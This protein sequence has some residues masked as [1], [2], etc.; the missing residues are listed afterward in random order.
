MGP[1]D[2]TLIILFLISFA[3]I[4]IYN[5]LRRYGRIGM[6]LDGQRG[7]VLIVIAHPDDECMFFAPTVLAL[8]RSGQHDVFLLCV[9]SGA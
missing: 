4:V 6:P 2:W 5:A 8:T 9:S 1:L 7:R 3:A